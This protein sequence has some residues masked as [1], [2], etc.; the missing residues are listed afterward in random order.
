MKKSQ[1][2]ASIGRAD[3]MKHYEKITVND[4]ITVKNQC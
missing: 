3:C 1:L 2:G 4:E